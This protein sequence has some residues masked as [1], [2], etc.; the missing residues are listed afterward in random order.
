MQPEQ[1]NWREIAAPDALPEP[2]VDAERASEFLGLRPRR[3]LEMARAGDLPAYPIGRG[4]RRTW[5]FRISEICK[6]VAARR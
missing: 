4:I 3:I 1:T 2:F 5:R 6:A